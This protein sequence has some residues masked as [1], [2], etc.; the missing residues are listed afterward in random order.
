MN[1]DI[2]PPRDEVGKIAYGATVPEAEQTTLPRLESEAASRYESTPSLRFMALMAHAPARAHKARDGATVLHLRVQ[3]CVVCWCPDRRECWRGLATSRLVVPSPFRVLLSAQ[4]PIAPHG[5]LSHSRLPRIHFGVSS[6]MSPEAG[7]TN[8]GGKEVVSQN[9]AMVAAM[10]SVSPKA[11]ACGCFSFEEIRFVGTSVVAQ[12]KGCWVLVP[13][14]AIMPGL[15]GHVSSL[16]S[17]SSYSSTLSCP[18]AFRHARR[19]SLCPVKVRYWRHTGTRAWI[20]S[21]AQHR[22]DSPPHHVKSE[23]FYRPR[24]PSRAVSRDTWALRESVKME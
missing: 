13:V 4:N 22:T 24:P 6:C 10:T 11:F 9:A 19:S 23:I 8:Y 5:T 20:V 18:W 21:K 7:R 14:R 16:E 1:H 12:L 15:R 17:A 3:S 2:L